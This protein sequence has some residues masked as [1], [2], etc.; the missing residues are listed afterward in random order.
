MR[1]RP[2]R[3]ILECVEVL[4]DQ[5]QVHDGFAVHGRLLGEILHVVSQ[6]VDDRLALTSQPLALQMGGRVAAV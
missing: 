6:A 3:Y 2:L 5:H 1:L 4:R